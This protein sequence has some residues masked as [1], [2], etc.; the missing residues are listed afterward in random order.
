MKP[1]EPWHR[2]HALMLAGQL[3][4]TSADAALMLQATPELMDTF[5]Q[6]QRL[7]PLPRTWWPS[8]QG[9]DPQIMKARRDTPAG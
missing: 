4:E 9:N 2:R 8:G 3:R 6:G 1:I 5:R 7:A